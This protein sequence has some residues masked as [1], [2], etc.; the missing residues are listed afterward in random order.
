MIALQGKHTAAYINNVFSSSSEALTYFNDSINI[1]ACRM[2]GDLEFNST[3]ST[4]SWPDITDTCIQQLELNIRALLYHSTVSG[5][6]E[7]LTATQCQIYEQ[8]MQCRMDCLLTFLISSGSMDLFGYIH[9]RAISCNETLF[10][11]SI[12]T[13]FNN[14]NNIQ[15]SFVPRQLVKGKII[16]YSF[17][18]S[19]LLSILVSMTVPVSTTIIPILS[20][21]NI[22]PSAISSSSTFITVLTTNQ[23]V[24]HSK[25]S[26][27]LSTTTSMQ[28]FTSSTVPSSSQLSNSEYLKCQHRF[29]NLIKL[30][31]SYGGREG[32]FFVCVLGIAFRFAF[33]IRAFPLS[34]SDSHVAFWIRLL[35]ENSKY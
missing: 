3:N 5:P 1:P 33:W 2:F 12:N 20:S 17:L 26:T 23:L 31:M 30:T 6:G 16:L 29:R 22:L 21:S 14:A 7:P 27:T 24:I 35:D 13:I 25:I 11:T 15:P 18:S 32:H 9:L 4:N 10:N 34:H 28:Y 8:T 19:F